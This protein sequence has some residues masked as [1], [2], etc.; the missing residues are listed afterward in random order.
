MTV[1]VSKHARRRAKER[2]NV[3]YKA[4]RNK[5]FNKA[6]RFGHN[7]NEFAGEFLDYLNSKTQKHKNTGIKVY[8]GNIYIYSNRNK[9]VITTYPVPQK[10][11][12]IQEQFA[13]YLKNNQ[14]LMR[15]YDVVDKSNVY[16]ETICS[17]KENV[18]TA[19]YIQDIFMNYGVGKTEVKSRNN[20]IKAYLKKVGKLEE[21][22]DIDE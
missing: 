17:D 18:I 6:L 3:S 1:K 21:G 5:L 4:E 10:F 9:L 7:T 16:I 13:S 14:C 11:L 8:D 20:A 19:L 2:L 15:L 12:P 22:E